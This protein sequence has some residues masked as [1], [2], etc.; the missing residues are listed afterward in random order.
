MSFP[1]PSR[2]GLRLPMN[3]NHRDHP[4]F[5]PPRA[6]QGTFG[7]IAGRPPAGLIAIVMLL[8]LAR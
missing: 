8:A 3:V 5:P 2:I 6:L 4:Y 7:L 1:V